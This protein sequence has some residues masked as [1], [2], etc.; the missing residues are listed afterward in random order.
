MAKK[1][2]KP[3]PTVHRTG[4]AGVIEFADHVYT[5]EI[6]NS[7]KWASPGV[8]PLSF[9]ST[10]EQEP[11]NVGQFRII[12]NGST[13]QFPQ[14]LREILEENNLSE[15]VFKRQR[16]LLWGQGPFLYTEKWEDNQK[17]RTWTEDSEVQDW[18]HSFDYEDMLR[19]A[20]VD[21]NH[22]EG[23]YAKFIRNR[24][25][26]I[27]YPSMIAR[28]ENVGYHRCR[29]EWPEVDGTPPK[30]IIAG[31]WYNP[32]LNNLKA[33]PV[34]NPLLPFNAPVSMIFSNMVSFA[35]DSY[36][37]PAFYGTLSWIRRGSS[38]PKILE[39]L[40]RNTLNIKYHIK[41]PA[42]YWEAKKE[43]LQNSCV[44]ENKQYTDKMLEDLKDE[45]FKQLG[46][47]LSGQDNVGKFFTSETILNEREALEDWKIEPIDMKV[48]DYIDS[49]LNI[50]RQADS[51]ITSGLGLHPSL[52]NIIVD[53]KL[54]SGS[55]Q[56]YAL[57]LYLATE[58]TIPENIVCKPLN[59]AIAAN[60]PSKKLK[61]GFYHDIVKT[62]DS[63]T[64]KDRLK[65]AV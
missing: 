59:L 41:S 33:Y 65:N 26:R 13:N 24:G 1:T 7:S 20:I 25:A 4:S 5:F 55:E 53:G 22:M 42:S 64:P 35:R 45:T 43:A 16:G 31:N 50:A 28:V 15:G 21:Y 8:M 30:N 27:G 57:K 60:W 47:V 49:Q 9:S 32:S 54:A 19:R 12:P 18:L 37:L 11:Y 51:A 52:S 23:H 44:N 29:L 48:K 38:I 3:F 63:T 34:F 2:K 39:A 61:V 46:V 36:G 6:S 58:T 56:L 10:Y 62:E 14:E 17:S 40:S